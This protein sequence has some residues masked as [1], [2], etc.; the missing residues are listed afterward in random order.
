MLPYIRKAFL[1]CLVGSWIISSHPLIGTLSSSNSCGKLPRKSSSASYSM[2]PTLYQFS[3]ISTPKSI[4]LQKE[5]FHTQFGLIGIGAIIL[6]RKQPFLSQLFPC[7][8]MEIGILSKYNLKRKSHTQSCKQMR[9]VT[10]HI[11]F[12]FPQCFLNSMIMP[13]YLDDRNRLSMQHL[14]LVHFLNWFLHVG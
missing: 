4:H 8:K 9:V 13:E 3:S 7:P 10:P 6:K 5:Y 11:V 12:C 2:L 14:L 1:P